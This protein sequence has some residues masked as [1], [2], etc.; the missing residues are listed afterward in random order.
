MDQLSFGR[1]VVV[2]GLLLWASLVLLVTDITYTRQ[3][4]DGTTTPRSLATTLSLP[5]CISLMQ[6]GDPY[7]KDGSFLTNHTIPISWQNRTDGSKQLQHSLCRLHR[8]TSQEAKQCLAGKH[9]NFLGD[10]LSRYQYMSLVWFL[11]KGSYPPHFRKP[12]RGYCKHMNEEGKPTC[13]PN[14]EPSICSVPDWFGGGPSNKSGWQWY[15]Q[16]M[17]STMFDGYM[18]AN[19]IKTEN[20]LRE[21]I[22]DNY[23]YASPS[24]RHDGSPDRPN[25][26]Q[27]FVSYV[28]D[29]V[30][31]VTMFHWKNCAQEGNCDYS[32]EEAKTRE[33]RA[34]NLDFDYSQSLAHALEETSGGI[35]PKLLPPVDIELYN[36][37]IWGL[38]NKQHSKT[39]LPLLHQWTHKNN[40]NNGKCFF[41][42]S[43]HFKWETMFE[44]ERRVVHPV[45][46]QAGCGYID[47]THLIQ[48]FYHMPKNNER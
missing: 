30:H 35:L 2:A 25:I 28:K 46:I 13:S 7:Y 44:Q 5:S 32:D 47:Y 22:V 4:V 34:I 43:T 23:F 36:R 24:T 16:S 42:S 39:V 26:D 1:T 29:T 37:G 14:D 20:L 31:P 19:A 27:V 40:N 3:Y 8:Y 18:E 41:R 21:K 11:H 6:S 48:E 10:S 15:A 45:A 12:G 38:M 17:G 33:Q 9:V